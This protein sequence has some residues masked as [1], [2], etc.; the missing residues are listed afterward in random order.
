MCGRYT[1]T[2]TPQQIALRFG[3]DPAPV[4]DLAPRY[5]I[6]P[7]QANPVVVNQDG[8]ALALMQWGLIPSWSREPSSR[9]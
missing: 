5:N 3:V 2:A 9:Y 7:S 8:P 4:A 6:A 1:L